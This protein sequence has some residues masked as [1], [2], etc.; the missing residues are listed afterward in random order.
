MGILYACRGCFIPI[1][2]CER[3]VFFISGYIQS[4]IHNYYYSNFVVPNKYVSLLPFSNSNIIAVRLRNTS[5]QVVFPIELYTSQ[6]FFRWS[7]YTYRPTKV[8]AVTLLLHNFFLS[9]LIP[10]LEF[11][12]DLLFVDFCMLWEKSKDYTV[13]FS[14][15]KLLRM[16]DDLYTVMIVMYNH[17]V[18]CESNELL[19]N[20]LTIFMKHLYIIICIRKQ[21]N[22]PRTAESCSLYCIDYIAYTILF[23]FIIIIILFLF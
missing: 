20:Y 4:R 10:I 12:F 23:F 3:C 5:L 8:K 16:S 21:Y 13:D 7:Y 15:K 17:I 9:C 6:I 1:K 2:T 22:P 19:L 14:V 11:F 18:I